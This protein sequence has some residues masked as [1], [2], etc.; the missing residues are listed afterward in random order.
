MESLDHSGNVR[1]VRP[2]TGGPKIHYRFD[3]AGNFM[4]TF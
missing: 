2:E 3:E 1:V 4:E